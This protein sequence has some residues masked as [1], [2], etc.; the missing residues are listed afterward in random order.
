MLE[1]ILG[2]S[3]FV[4]HSPIIVYM[5]QKLTQVAGIIGPDTNFEASIMIYMQPYPASHSNC[6]LLL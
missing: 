3:L 6:E 4:K 5:A 1:I 2:P